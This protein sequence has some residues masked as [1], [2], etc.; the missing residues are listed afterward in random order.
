M[1]TEN[2]TSSNLSKFLFSIRSYTPVPF[3]IVMIIF[4]K[5]EIWSLIAGF[6][7]VIAGELFRFGGVS[8][9]GSETRTTDRT[10]GTYLV[11][12]GAF[13]YL[14]NPLY[15]G[16]ILIYFGF[17]VASLALAPYLQIFAMIYFFF[18][19]YFIV[20][21]EEAYLKVRFGKDYENY[22]K[23]VPAFIPRLTPYKNPGIEQPGY[24]PAAGLR[25]EKR[26]LQAII[27][28]SIILIVKYFYPF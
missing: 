2:N 21:A 18:Q 23:S 27:L 8:R 25:S 20:Q 28:V 24:N 13:A 1:S 17:G 6:L 12:S 14:R 9:A 26:T 19:Y 7:I 15:L 3:L 11:V 22:C 4:G 16:N 5:P 10:G